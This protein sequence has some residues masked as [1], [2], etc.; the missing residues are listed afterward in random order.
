MG[1]GGQALKSPRALGRSRYQ[2]SKYLTTSEFST[3]L[4]THSL[5]STPDPKL[6]HMGWGGQ[7]LKT[8]CTIAFWG[9]ATLSPPN[10]NGLGHPG[11][12]D[13]QLNAAVGA[14]DYVRGSGNLLL[15][16]CMKLTFAVASR[17]L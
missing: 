17:E 11:F 13:E 2:T 4:I 1:W 7:V 3:V 16:S 10:P 14:I 15:T 6:T 8:A 9:I 12:F 5:T